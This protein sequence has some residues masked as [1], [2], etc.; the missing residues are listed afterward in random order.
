M[1]L[2]SSWRTIASTIGPAVGLR[3]HRRRS[4][5]PVDGAGRLPH[6]ESR[7]ATLPFTEVFG[8]AWK[9][10]K[11]EVGARIGR[12]LVRARSDSVRDCDSAAPT[13]EQATRKQE[14]EAARRRQAGTSAYWLR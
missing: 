5:T 12:Q 13:Q 1:S 6:Q 7:N 3:S 2:R 11:A 14:R 8:R 9:Q 4:V 10:T